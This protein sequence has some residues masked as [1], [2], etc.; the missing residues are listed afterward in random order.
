MDKLDVNL[1]ELLQKNSRM[2]V[3]DLS[4]K[5]SLSRPSV[6]ERMI[7]LQEKGVIE[8]FTTRVSLD[9]IGRGSILFIQLSSLKVSPHVIDQMI[10]DDKDII[11]CHR[12]TGHI[13]YFIKAAVSNI[14]GM[15]KLIDRFIPCGVVTTSIVISSPVPY[16]HVLPL[17]EGL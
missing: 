14:E 2:T 11:E 1:L 7:R 5:L 9:A 4:K 3:S 8:E 10:I 17:L 13:D 6:A 15:K 12:V 16:R